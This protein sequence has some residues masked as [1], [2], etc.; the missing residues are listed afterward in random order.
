M[1]NNVFDYIKA[2]ETDFKT[3]Q[4]P[5]ADGY[6]F[7]LYEHV[8]MST[9]F[10]DSK[11]TKGA[12]DYSRPFKNI[13]RRIRNLALVA[14]DIDVKDIE[15][16]VNDADNYYKSFI[17]RKYHPRWA[18]KYN[19][20]TFIDQTIESYED[21]GLALTKHINQIAPENVPLQSIAFCD[22]NDILSGPICLKHQYSPAQLKEFDGKWKNID[23]VIRFA[24][25][26]YTDSSG[27]RTSKTPGKFIEVYEL[28]G[29]FPKSW[30]SDEDSTVTDEDATS[31]SQQ[32]HIV[33][34]YQ[35]EQGDKKG[36]HLYKGKG[37][38]NKYKAI[39]RD[40]IFGRCAGMG[41]IEELFHPQIW[42]N[43]DAIRIQGM[44][45]AASKIWYQTDDTGFT[46]RNNPKDAENN[47][48]FITAEGKTVQQVNTQPINFNTFQAASAEWENHAQGIGS[49]QGPQLGEEPTSGTPFKLYEAAISQGKGL[50]DKRKGILA[51]YFGEIYRDWILADFVKDI[52][53]G[54]KFMEEISLDEM[55]Y[56][57]DSIANCYTKKTLDEKVLSGQNIEEGEKE[58][59]IAQIKDQF[60][61]GGSKRFFELFKDEL[62]DL[63][64]D[65]DINI[66][67]KQKNLS[68]MTDKVVN[69]V[70]QFLANPQILQIPGMAKTFNQILE[71]S[72]LSPVDFSDLMAMPMMQPQQPQLS[73]LQ[74]NQITQ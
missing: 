73:P 4:V 72:G 55:Q 32:L 17:V 8:R 59:M 34:F 19:I 62:K 71:S 42:V 58:A 68:G 31:Y 67:G 50:H 11:Y 63:P 33:T 22:Q 46:T 7:N 37:D 5:V 14:M 18:R 48:V 65:V 3:R 51:T 36:I 43:Y 30:L 21:F 24:R 53:K 56:L 41:G 10:R 9:L 6:E 70:R 74:N 49:A 40:D 23:D 2:E 15:P 16:F 66:A 61:K 38:L 54:Q 64:V 39:K 52:N 25:K 44:L 57:A 27:N 26:E 60:K 20:D 28:D 1:F 12:N 29:M 69:I 35:N 47:E 13:I 45:D